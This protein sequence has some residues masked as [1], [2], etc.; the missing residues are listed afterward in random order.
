MRDRGRLDAGGD[1]ELVKHVRD[2]DA[3]GL[4]AGVRRQGRNLVLASPDA[5]RRGAVA[6]SQRIKH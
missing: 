2:G 3:D 1:V 5:A 4:D 6:L